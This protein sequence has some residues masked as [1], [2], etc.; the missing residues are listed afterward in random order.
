M[1][2]L[3]KNENRPALSGWPMILGWLAM[4]IFACHAS[5]HMV[6]AGDTW[7]AMACGRHFVNHGV[8]TVEP[9]SANSHRA[10]PTQKDIESWPPAAKWIANKVGLNTVKYWHPTGWVNQNWL[11]HVIFYLLT[12]E[13]SYTPSDNFSS[14][15]LV[16]W[17]FA[18]YILTTIC[19]YYTARLLGVNPA[20]SAVFACFAI[21]VGRSLFDIRP[22][23]FSNL[24]VAVFLLILV[25]VTYRN[26]LYI[27]LIVP[28]GVFWCNVHGGYIYLFIML[29]PFAALNLLMSIF[30][31][32]FVSIGLKGVCHI[33]AAGFAAFL[34]VILFNPFHLTNLTHTFVISVSKHAA[35]WRGI[36]EWHPAFE[37][38]NPVGNPTPFLIMFIITWVVLFIWCFVM[39]LAFHSV[40]RSSRHRGKSTD[41][42][43][44]P[45][46]DLALLAVV[47][48]TVYMAV[49]SRRFMPIAAIAACPVI[50]MF[51]DQ[52]VRAIAAA[53]NF[54]KH[55]CLTVSA[56]PRNLQLF[57]IVCGVAAIVTFGSYAGLKFK[58]VYLDPWPVDE[59]F[60]S[61]FMRMT[62][63]DVKP[64]YAC[65]FIKDNKLKGKMFN[66]WTEGGFIA[67]A[68]APDPN[69][70]RTPLQLFMD[71]RAQAAY[72]PKDYKVWSQIM[73]VAPFLKKA[74]ARKHKFTAKDYVEIGRWI[75]KELR[76]RDV[77]LVL[78]PLKRYQG[79][80]VK[81]IETNSDW[82]IV[83][84]DDEQRIY[85]DI[86][87]AQAQK[88]FE[89]IFSGKTIYPNDFCKNLIM[90]RNMRLFGKDEA[91]KKQSLDYAI[92]AFELNPSYVSTVEVISPATFTDL[93]PR[94]T[95]FCKEYV[96]NFIKN[97]NAS[98]K[99]DGHHHR[100]IAAFVACD[101][102]R[103]VAGVY[104]KP[105]DA[106]FYRDK[107]KEYEEK[108]KQIGS[109]K[110]W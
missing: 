44:W 24:L 107:T 43:R 95:R 61:V 29:V 14:N 85:I 62:N 76:K 40:S 108:L 77:W 47:V 89:G 104:K 33:I 57:F 70:G 46:L 65:K 88:L 25:L 91:A 9:F 67:W 72:E 45:Q 105:E 10:G 51:I 101:Y 54:H 12:P 83:F 34:A 56:M 69:T 49:R 97:E 71:G 99:Q 15:A 28:L 81:G 63:S 16:Y 22:A 11:T 20:L 64:F 66:E 110:N 87:T 21:F 5:T 38:D 59:K 55:N 58:R 35:M 82:V 50:A 73:F 109:E 75:T 84:F 18:V 94:V 92:K 42:Y 4:L 106:K 79:D 52:I 90:A 17:K 39:L 26:I 96:E 8:D 53:R 100:A 103:K 6:G 36:R 80:F 30:K 27:W 7:V 98:L 1:A 78:M 60:N 3:I 41:Q 93:Q 37:W 2:Q 19:V 86:A 31:K 48:L 23:G 13:S 74:A 102:L 68:Q 32:G